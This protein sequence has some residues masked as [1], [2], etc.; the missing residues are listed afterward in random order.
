[1]PAEEV[2]GIRIALR[3]RATAARGLQDTASDVE[4]IGDAAERAGRKSRGALDALTKIGSMVGRTARLGAT[5]LGALGAVG[6]A[7]GLKIAAANEQ[8]QISFTTMLGS[9]QK[10]GSFLGDL[11]SFAADT[12]FEFPELQTAA[13][14]LVSAGVNAS[15]VI[16]IMTSLGNATSGMGTGSEG[17][18][19]ATRALQQMSAAGRITAE[20]FN[21]L[22]DAG[23]PVFGL[24]AA[25]TG[26]SVEAIAELRDKGRLGRTELEQ[27]F[28]AL[29]SGKGLERFAGL[30]DKQSRSLTGRWA[31]FTDT[32]SMGLGEALAPWMP[33]LKLGLQRLTDAAGPFFAGLTAASADLAR[34]GPRAVNMVTRAAQRAGP[35][36]AAARGEVTALL[37]ELRSGPGVNMPALRDIGASAVALT[38]ILP[39]LGQQMPAIN[40]GLAVMGTVMGFLAEHVDLLAWAMPG[41][42]LGFVAVKVAQ[43]GANVAS[44]LS[45]PL[46]LWELRLNWQLVRSNNAL[47]A[48]S[49]G[50]AAATAL[51]TGAT[52]RA[53]VATRAGRI[54]SL[55]GGA[56]SKVLALGVRG[57]GLALRF[58]TGPVGWIVTGLAALTAAAVWFFTKTELGQS[59]I[60]RFTVKLVELASWAQRL[61]PILREGL[62]SALGSIVD[63]ARAVLKVVG[64][65]AQFTPLGAAVSL[66]TGN[67]LPGRARGGPVAAGRPYVVGEREPEVFVPRQSG[68]IVPSL[69][70]YADE[71]LDGVLAGAGGAPTVVQLVVDRKVLAE[72]TVK[73]QR[74]QRARR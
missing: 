24:L 49:K 61:G 36:L 34:H 27:L 6:V 44:T 1:M 10:A 40:D 64:K 13:S 67:G 35:F 70:R 66:A 73:E 33:T 42:A 57:V 46:K 3:D 51:T 39:A 58:A 50:A 72:A 68:R 11:R 48:S 8:A 43:A 7:Q 26:K 41:L 4:E 65:V 56:A 55:A 63:K 45:I 31:N 60:D 2:I 23:V 54:A 21:Q 12:P 37:D 74:H 62:V 22:N 69:E 52:T 25:A 15:K 53:T 5:A 47:A 14:S 20:D 9:A 71:D 32:V 30:M 59:I 38:A 18:A 29:E 19:R 16:P 17:I 28:E